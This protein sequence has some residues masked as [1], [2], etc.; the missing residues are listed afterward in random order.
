MGAYSQP[1]ARRGAANETQDP[2]PR[3][4]RLAGPVGR[5]RPEQPMLDRVPLRAA[6]RIMAHGHGQPEPVA[7]LLLQLL[8]PPPGLPAVAA[9]AVGQDQ[10]L[11][12]ARIHSLPLLS[13]P[14]ADRGDAK[15]RRIP[16]LP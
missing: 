13:P 1:R 12:S 16:R 8:L 2:L 10:Q 6:G 5:D 9:A 11:V 15:P 14:T 4:Q 7:Q 3:A